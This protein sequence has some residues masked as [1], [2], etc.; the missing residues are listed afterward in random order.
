MGSCCNPEAL[1]I[2]P[3]EF[4]NTTDLKLARRRSLSLEGA[5][6]P[7]LQ[8]ADCGVAHDRWESEI[9]ALLSCDHQN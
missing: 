5:L 3:V 6:P 8:S 1:W 9:S 2:R 4:V 7:A